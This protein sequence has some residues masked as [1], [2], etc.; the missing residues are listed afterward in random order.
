MHHRSH[1]QGVSFQGVSFQEVSVQGGLCPGGFLS[2]GSLSRGS[3]SGGLCLGV[4]VLRGL[5]LGI[6]GTETPQQRSPLRMVTSGWYASY[7]NGFL[8]SNVFFCKI[9]TCTNTK[10]H[11]CH[12]WIAM[13][14]PSP[15]LLQLCCVSYIRII[16]PIYKRD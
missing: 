7:W 14:F 13:K 2:R 11:Y 4:S 16:T 15:H 9:C 5:C 1:D 10:R 3:L 12:Q 8:S 6:S